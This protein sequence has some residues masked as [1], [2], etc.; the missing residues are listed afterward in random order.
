MYLAVNLVQV[1][2]RMHQRRQIPRSG[3]YFHK[4]GFYVVEQTAGHSTCNL[5]LN[6]K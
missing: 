3:I 1:Q 4:K 5:L 2:L 6:D